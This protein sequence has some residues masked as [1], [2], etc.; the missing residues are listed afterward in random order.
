MRPAADSASSIEHSSGSDFI[1]QYDFAVIA[2]KADGR[3][4]GSA[5]GDLHDASRTCKQGDPACVG[6]PAS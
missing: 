6:R 2:R 4:D 3:P 1:S 5:R